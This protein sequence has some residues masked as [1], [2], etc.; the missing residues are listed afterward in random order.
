MLETIVLMV[1][2]C[3][4]AIR[5]FSILSKTEIPKHPKPLSLNLDA[6]G[7]QDFLV[8]GVGGQGRTEFRGSLC[9]HYLDTKVCG[10]IASL[11]AFRIG[12]G[13]L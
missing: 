2:W 6:A 8:A 3:T 4:E 12:V 1:V 9:S 13:V 5:I 7:L 10:K 11:T